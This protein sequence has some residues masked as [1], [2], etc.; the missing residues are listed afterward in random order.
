MSSIQSVVT[1]QKVDGSWQA[2]HVP[3]GKVTH[4][5][6]KEEAEEAMRQMLG[7]NE[8]GEFSEPITSDMFEGLGK[9]IAEY[10]EGPVSKMLSAHSGYARLE[11]YENGV[12]HVRLGGGCEGCPASSMTLLQGVKTSL[13]DHFGEDRV[14]DITP[15]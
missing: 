13:Q 12:A 4:G 3:S 5:L 8:T 2:Q 7:V 6:T 11:A 9:E 15:A 10:L 14:V 1:S